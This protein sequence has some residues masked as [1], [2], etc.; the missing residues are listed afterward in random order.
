VPLADVVERQA[1][2]GPRNAMVYVIDE[3]TER[4]DDG[5]SSH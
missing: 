2:V 4:F 5:L 1:S 3:A